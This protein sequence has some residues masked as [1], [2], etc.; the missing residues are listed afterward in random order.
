MSNRLK[1]FAPELKLLCKFNNNRKQRWLE[2]NLNDSLILC[3]CECSLNILRGNIPLQPKQ[4][5]MLAKH[6]EDLRKLIDKKISIK[7]KRQILQ[8]GGFIGTL[9]GPIVSILSGLL[10]GNASN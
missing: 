2:K 7:K 10:G 4:K 1:E 5:K 6:K 8:N 3:L 9:L